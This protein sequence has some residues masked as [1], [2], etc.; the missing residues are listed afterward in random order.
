MFESTTAS[1]GKLITPLIHSW[2]A[3][4]SWASTD[5]PT[6]ESSK[7]GEIYI[8]NIKVLLGT[9]QASCMYYV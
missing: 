3:S 5:F 4:V 7:E 1:F 9:D 8:A 6:S 2:A